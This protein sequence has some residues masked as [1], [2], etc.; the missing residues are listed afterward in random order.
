LKPDGVFLANIIGGSS[1]QELRDSFYLAD[2]ERRGG[3]SLH[4]SP[5]ILPSDMAS[6]MQAAGFAL[7]GVDIDTIKVLKGTVSIF[8]IVHQI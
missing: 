3:A 5:M 4:S 6:L 8:S 2:R 1:L 7:S